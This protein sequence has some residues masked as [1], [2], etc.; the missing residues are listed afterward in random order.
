MYSWTAPL[1]ERTLTVLGYMVDRGRQRGDEIRRRAAT[2]VMTN[3]C[4]VN[5][6]STELSGNS[7]QRLSLRSGV[8]KEAGQAPKAGK[9][10]VFARGD[11]ALR[12]F[13]P[14]HGLV[15]SSRSH[16]PRASSKSGP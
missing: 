14:K 12:R 16:S 15:L 8:E 2:I 7:R 11:D 4:E 13:H 1:E 10:G 3:R 9:Q 5:A 6:D